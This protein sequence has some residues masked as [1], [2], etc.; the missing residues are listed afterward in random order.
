[1]IYGSC[2]NFVSNDDDEPPIYECCTC[3]LRRV[4]WL[5]RQ[6]AHVVLC[7]AADEP[8]PDPASYIAGSRD[9]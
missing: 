1:V 5:V 3:R 9:A 4:G 7:H 6:D 2:T 8:C